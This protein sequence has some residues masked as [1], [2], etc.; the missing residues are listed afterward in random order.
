MAPVVHFLGLSTEL[1]LR[2]LRV[3]APDGP[4]VT[5]HEIQTMIAEG[6]EA[7]VLETTQTE[8]MERVFRLGDRK[9][10]AF[11]TPRTEIVWLDVHDGPKEIRQ[12]ITASR[13]SRFPVAEGGLENVI[14]VVQ[15]RDLIVQALS[16]QR[17]NLRAIMQPA[18][19]V[20]AGM[21][22]LKMLE[23]FR[24]TKAHMLMLL[25]EYG[26]M[27]GLVTLN[28]IAEAIAGDVGLEDGIT[29]PG[30]IQREDGS[31]LLDGGLVIDK[32]KEL[33]HLPQLPEE[34]QYQT[35]AGFVLASLGRIP[36]SGTHFELQDW[37]VEV[38]DMDGPRVDK[39]LLKQ[40]A[41]N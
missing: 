23:Q 26:G 2:L 4:S 38:V 25:D 41:P 3:K 10:S 21:P 13:H 22:V 32:F 33:V 5:S 16:R 1:V 29:E 6:A 7:G 28:D 9:G 35:L 12:K 17:I 31:W 40:Q 14:G 20:P 37:R 30:I 15:A 19:F 39:V 36:V 34:G 27:Q 11:I 18:V 8:I 24:T